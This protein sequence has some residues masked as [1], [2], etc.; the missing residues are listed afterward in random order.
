MRLTVCS[1]SLWGGIRGGLVAMVGEKDRIILYYMGDSDI[2]KKNAGSRFGMAGVGRHERTM[3]DNGIA[4]YV[5]EASFP[6]LAIVID[7]SGSS[8]GLLVLPPP[9]KTVLA[10]RFAFFWEGERWSDP[11]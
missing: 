7:S 3:R 6:F 4:T 10:P 11:C 5:V 2:S 8:I 1:V 9:E